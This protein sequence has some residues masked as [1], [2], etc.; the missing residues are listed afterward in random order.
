[1]SD[2]VAEIDAYIANAQPSLQPVLL[3]LRRRV[4]TALPEVEEAIKWGA[5]SF[6]Y[7]GKI[8]C[9]M[10]AFKAHATFGFWH[11]AMVTGGTSGQ[12]FAMGDL[13]RLI[14]VEDL[15]D[16]ATMAQWIGRARE[17]VDEGVRPPHMEGR[18]KHAK[19]E[20]EMIPAFQTALNA[21]AAA[22]A[23]YDGFAPSCRREYLEWIAE[24]KRED[25]RARRIEQAITWLADGKRRN[26]KY[27]KRG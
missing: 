26:W 19:P 18:G 24:A 25:T 8:L 17:L 21:S 10:A 27:E 5:P 9:S 22:K 3:E 2:A 14:S 1:M 7:K 13:G 11:G 16:G 6:I 23:T 15:P 12:I 20:L 4:R